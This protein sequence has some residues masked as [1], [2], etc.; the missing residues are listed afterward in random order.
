M[1]HT[2]CNTYNRYVSFQHNYN[3]YT[4]IL[5]S[6]IVTQRVRIS[7]MNILSKLYIDFNSIFTKSFLQMT[8][9]MVALI[10]PAYV[11]AQTGVGILIQ[12]HQLV[13]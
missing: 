4:C 11:L 5:Q 2:V 7:Y 13:A 10:L 9:V 12:S 8:A 6:C 3:T 1:L